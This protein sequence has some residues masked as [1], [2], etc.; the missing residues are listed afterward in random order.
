MPRISKDSP[1]VTFCTGRKPIFRFNIDVTD[2]ALL[3][4]IRWYTLWRFNAEQ[5]N[6]V[7]PASRNLQIQFLCFEL[8][9]EYPPKR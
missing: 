4:R 9:V 6:L 8:H 1:D 7:N 5:L 2:W 3:L